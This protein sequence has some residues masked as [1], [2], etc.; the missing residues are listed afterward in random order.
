M[1]NR[2]LGLSRGAL[3]PSACNI[4]NAL[5]VG[6]IDM[7]SGVTLLPTTDGTIRVREGTPNPK[8]NHCFGIAIGGDVDGVYGD[9]GNSI[10]DSIRATNAAGQGVQVLTQGRCLAKVNG[11]GIGLGTPVGGSLVLLA[12]P[13]GILSH[14]P[15]PT[16]GALIIARALAPVA[17]FDT[18]MIPVD[19]QREDIL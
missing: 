11:L 18:D 2:Y 4:I 3:D 17:E 7:G 14:L 6:I 1:T 8:T 5:S 13:G 16:L 10:D 19:I 12:N 15:I 9:G